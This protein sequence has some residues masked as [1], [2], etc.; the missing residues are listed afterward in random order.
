[1]YVPV[2]GCFA[3]T[4]YF[5]L[6]RHF[7]PL[8]HVQHFNFIFIYLLHLLY[9]FKF[10]WP[11]IRPTI[12][13]RTTFITHVSPCVK[14]QVWEMFIRVLQEFCRPGA[15]SFPEVDGVLHVKIEGKKSWRKMYCVLRQSA[16][17][18]SKSR[19]K[20]GENDSSIHPKKYWLKWL[21]SSSRFVL[22]EHQRSAVFAKAGQSWSVHWSRL[23][24]KV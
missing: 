15:T 14:R 9:H 4:M 13:R 2:G 20:V 7:V 18:C 22:I 24:E 21:A 3:C 11:E 12:P 6:W 17:Y 19:S 8:V 16:L 5:S 23:A 1:M 10:S